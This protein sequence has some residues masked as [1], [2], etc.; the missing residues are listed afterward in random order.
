MQVTITKVIV[1]VVCTVALITVVSLLAASAT[2]HPAPAAHRTPAHL[3]PRPHRTQ[4]AAAQPGSP[5]PFHIDL[6]ALAGVGGC[7]VVLCA[8]GVWQTRRRCTTCGY[9]PV[10][11]GCDELAHH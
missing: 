2:P 6:T 9:C 7:L 5:F 11:C 10:F 3:V 8:W 4:A 1:T